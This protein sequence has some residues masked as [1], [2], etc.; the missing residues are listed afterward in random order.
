MSI[1]KFN[2]YKECNC[3]CGGCDK[4][5]SKVVKYEKISE[6]LKYHL[7]SNQLLTENVFR[8]YSDAFLEIFNEARYHF[9][10]GNIELSE[11]DQEIIK[12]DIGQK[13]IYEGKEVY[14][15]LPMVD[16][17]EALN[18]VK[19]RGKNVKTSK[20]SR[21][22]SGGKAYKVYVS[23]CNEKT[24]SNPKGVKLIRFGSGGLKAKVD[25]PEARQRYDSRHGCSEGKHDDKCKAGYWSCRL[26][27]YWHIISGNKKISALWW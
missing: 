6:N 16:E 7:E 1:K 14:L 9:N 17:E 25:D 4:G 27:R 13:A 26:P 22:S 2:E 24:D 18:E 11:I 21:D 10:E 20:P 3:G 5:E 12:T 8:I 15:D 19:Y 23:G